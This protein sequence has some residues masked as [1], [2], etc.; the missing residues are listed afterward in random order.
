LAPSELIQTIMGHFII[1]LAFLAAM[2]LGLPMLGILVMGH[3]VSRYLEFPPAFRYVSHAPFSRIAFA[4]YAG[5]IVAVVA[6]FTI[7][8][9]RRA[10]GKRSGRA[11][12]CSF[13]WWGWLG[14]A[15]GAT[16]WSLAWTRFS[17]F[18]ALQPH[19]FTPLWLSYIVVINALTHRKT[20]HCL[21][22]DRTGFFSLLFPASAG[23]WWFFE[24][25]NRFV[26]NWYYSGSQYGPW[27]YFF[28]AT[29]SFS[30]VLPA[31]ASTR[32]WVLTSDRLNHAFAGAWPLMI[33]RP[34]GTAWMILMVSGGGLAGIG[35]APDL[36]FPL[37]WVSP[38]LIIV[39]LQVLLQEP[40]IF[41]SL[42]TGDWRPVVS[43]A[44]SALIC[45]FFW[46]MWNYYSLA[47]WEYAVPLVHRF[48]I[49]EMPVLGYAGYL[50]F[51]LAC[52]VVT[53]MLGG[54][55]PVQATAVPGAAST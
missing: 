53:E 25:L 10:G 13:P 27:I 43:A 28:L 32:E 15:A 22:C 55:C 8:W 11:I 12:F 14:I 47:R 39:S 4:A 48:R 17:W 46:E 24:Y 19:T 40:H 9:V 36:L 6:P 37:L 18:S 26:Q 5:F 44:I 45:G 2:L 54:N 1:K 16:T 30:T 23:F 38:L 21:M 49:F 42:P 29:L 33:S 31:V 41:G 20:G 34:R 51:G 3:P 52:A 7:Q 35:I 50:P